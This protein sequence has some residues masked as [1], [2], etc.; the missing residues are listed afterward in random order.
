MQTSYISSLAPA[1][2]V[3][4]DWVSNPRI[5][6]QYWTVAH[7]ELGHGSGGRVQ[8][9]ACTHLPLPWNHPFSPHSAGPQNQKDWGPLLWRT[10]SF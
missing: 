6:A 3:K 5:L 10:R 9:H 4:W 7:S 1:G 2:P 8:V